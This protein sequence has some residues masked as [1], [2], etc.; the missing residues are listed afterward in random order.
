VS[1]APWG[2][3]PLRHRD[4]L[5][6]PRPLDVDVLNDAS[7]P[8]HGEHDFAAYCRRKEHATTIR[9]ISEL[10]W[11]REPDGVVVATVQADAFCQAMVRS[12][13][14]ALLPTGSGRRP[15]QWPGSLLRSQERAGDVVVAPPH[16][17]TL[18]GVGYPEDPADYA[19]RAELTRE[20]RGRLAGGPAGPGSG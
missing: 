17:L 3:A 8:L 5:A 2:A 18:T 4:T 16:G 10:Y 14:G 20:L 15:A 1:D 19:R 11:H 13:V 12:L 7:R 9:A 6:W